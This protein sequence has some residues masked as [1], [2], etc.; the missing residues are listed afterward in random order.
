MRVRAEGL[1]GGVVSWLDALVVGGGVAGLATAFRLRQRRPEAR[2]AVLEAE[3]RAGGNVRT[4][5][6]DGCVVDLGP[7][8]LVTSPAEGEAICEELGLGDALL[9]PNPHARRVFVAHREA[10]VAMPEGLA[11]G[12]PRDLGSLVSTPLLS[13]RGKLRAACDLILPDDRQAR[14]SLGHIVG[15]RLGQEVKERLVEPLVGGIY[16]GDIDRLDAAVVMPALAAQ[17]GSILRTMARAPRQALALR[18]PVGGMIRLVT[19]LSR[20]VG[21]GRIILGTRVSRASPVPGGWRV[22]GSLGL[23]LLT[24]H[25]VLAT[26]AHAAAGIVSEASPEL[27]ARLGALPSLSSAS[28]VLAFDGDERKLPEG[29]GLLAPRSEGL[30]FLAATFLNRKWPAR[31]RPGRVVVRAVVGSHRQAPLLACDDATIAARVLADLRRYISPGEPLWWHVERYDRATP[32]PEVGHRA[33]VAQAREAAGAL[34]GLSLVGAS[35]DGP[36]LAGCLRQAQR[37]A[38]A[39][40]TPRGAGAGGAPGRGPSACAGRGRGA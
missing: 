26:P 5:V 32:Q 40:L 12:M 34:G 11:M 28:V 20:A 13:W 3:P 38:E 37:L 21:P 19:A 29:S 33:R 16:G 31:I 18:A 7:D 1:A 23:E 4:L 8:V 9:E 15:K 24:R 17:R 27:V 22:Q 10:P 35:Y 6:R 39:L 2:V 14:Q 36:G 30:S 25:L